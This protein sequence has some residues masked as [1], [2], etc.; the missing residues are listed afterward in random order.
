[1][2]APAIPNPF[3]YGQIL[4]PGKAFC[5]RPALESSVLE[6]AA[7]QHRVV[8]LGDRRMGKSSLVEHTLDQR[9]R[10]LIPV[11]LRGLDSVDDFIDRLL[12]RLATKIEEHRP[13]AKHLPVAFKE[14]LSF[15]SEVRVSLRGVFEMTA[16][17]KP[18]ASTVIQ[19]M[20]AVERASRW[21]PLAVF[22]DEFQEIVES[23]EEREARHLLGVIRGEI[24]RHSKVAYLFAG[25]ARGSMLELFT[26]ERSHFY[27]SATLLE[28]GPIPQADMSNFLKS[29][30][31]RGGRDVSAATLQ[32]IFA[33]AGPSPNDQQQLAYH[34]WT[35]STPGAIGLEE[36][37]NAFAALLAEVNRRGEMLL[38]EAT[39]AQRRIL[40]AVALREDEETSTDSFIRFAGFQSN[41]SVASALRPFLKGSNAVL[42][43]RGSKVHYRERFMRLWALVQLL[44]TP[45]I[46]PQ[47]RVQ[48]E[49]TEHALLLP[50]LTT[51]VK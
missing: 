30:F 12:L 41:S 5:P 45:S 15:V 39:P 20:N 24:Q 4:L 34:L 23:L 11:D 43:K 46:F 32:A 18:K 51:A 21:K 40:F 33:L 28:V 26:A 10:I 38:D 2:A 37:Q 50:Y 31:A 3:V 8:L 6:A 17:A 9:E 27:Q 47:G 13:V 19:A 29:Q 25:S 1:M 48:V 42:E 44:K 49:N 16:R 14:A 36:L 35:Q 22:F 7:N